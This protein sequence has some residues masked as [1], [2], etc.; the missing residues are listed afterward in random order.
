MSKVLGRA[1]MEITKGRL[2][3]LIK[4]EVARAATDEESTKGS[5]VADLIINEFRAMNVND[6]HAF[7]SKL[8][9]FLNEENI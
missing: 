1:I 2:R 6:R 7:L 3:Q 4:E 5:K 8:V 9:N